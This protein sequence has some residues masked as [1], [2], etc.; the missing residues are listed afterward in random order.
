MLRSTTILG[1]IRKISTSMTLV[2]IFGFRIIPLPLVWI[3]PLSL[4]VFAFTRFVLWKRSI[5]VIPSIF[6]YIVNLRQRRWTNR[7]LMMIHHKNFIM[8]F[9]LRQY[10]NSLGI[11]LVIVS[12]VLLLQYS[13]RQKHSKQ[14]FSL[15]YRHPLANSHKTST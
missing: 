10:M 3:R 2:V 4:V 15:S 13:I 6:L 5:E 7:V 11:K 9:C 12:A 14:C 1:K 8:F